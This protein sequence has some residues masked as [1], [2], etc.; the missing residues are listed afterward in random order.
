MPAPPGDPSRGPSDAR[1][2]PGDAGKGGAR[3][4]FGIGMQEML[5]IFV[6]ALLVF[7]PKRLPELA[8]TLG[9]S[10]AE[11]RRASAD[12]RAAVLETPPPPPRPRAAEPPGG[13]AK[14]G[15]PAPDPD[16][17]PAVPGPE[18]E[19]PPSGAKPAGDEKAGA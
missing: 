2:A 15:G 3:R 16:A 4:V 19:P 14:A 8:R 13:A 9:R 7:G 18:G 1:R 11:F 12:L 17:A 10:L 6:I 5:V